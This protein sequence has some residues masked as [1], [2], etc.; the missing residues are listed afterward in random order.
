M[1][2]N[3]ICSLNNEA[4]LKALFTFQKAIKTVIEVEETAIYAKE[5]LQAKKIKNAKPNP[6]IKKIPFPNFQQHDK[7]IPEMFIM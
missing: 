2:T 1:R 6:N 4:V 3:F 7:K 5:T